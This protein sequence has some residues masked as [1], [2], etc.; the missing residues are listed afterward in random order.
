MLKVRNQ[1]AHDYDCD[2]VKE[3]R[4][5]I[6]GTYIDLLYEFKRAVKELLA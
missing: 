6:I 4:N 1:L 3:H 5:T 2:I